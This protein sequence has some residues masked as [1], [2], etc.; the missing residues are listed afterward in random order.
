VTVNDQID[1]QKR[2]Q[3]AYAVT[4]AAIEYGL[5]A[6][7]YEGS[8]AES[9]M[10]KWMNKEDAHEVFTAIEWRL[11]DAVDRAFRLGLC[12]KAIEGLRESCIDAM[13]QYREHLEDLDRQDSARVA[14]AEL[15][16]RSE[17]DV[18]RANKT[19]PVKVSGLEKMPGLRGP[20][21]P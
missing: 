19:R 14:E 18:R 6:N 21:T 7:Y 5:I 10:P 9:A 4:F 17:R 2:D 13:V 16:K 20:A 3:A 8:H 11:R 1:R 15:R 12:V